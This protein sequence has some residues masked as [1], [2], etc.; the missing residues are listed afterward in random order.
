MVDLNE[1]G[2]SLA[3]LDR[4]VHIAYLAFNRTPSLFHCADL[5]C[6]KTP[7]ALSSP[8]NGHQKPALCDPKVILGVNAQ[9]FAGGQQ[10]ANGSSPQSH[11]FRIKQE[12][13][14]HLAIET[15]PIRR[16]TCVSRMARGDI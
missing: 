5:S 6:S 2:S 15:I 11:L 12:H 4:E 16:L 8:M 14:Q 1:V 7:I 9:K 13:A 3:V 10:L